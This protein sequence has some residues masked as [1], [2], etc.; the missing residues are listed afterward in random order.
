MPSADDSAEHE[1]F[2]RQMRAVNERLVVA[3]VRAEQLAEEAE[4]ARSAAADSEERFRSLVQASSAIVW[5]AD[6]S[7]TI[8]FASDAWL[9]FTGVRLDASV[10]GGWL[11]AVHADDRE[12]VQA[13]WLLAL[14]T[15][16]LYECE[17]RLQRQAGGY[18]WVAS[19]AVPIVRGGVAREWI[20]MMSD[21]TERIE[22]E[23]AREQFM[24]ILGHDLRSPLTAISISGQALQHLKLDPPYGLLVDDL[25]EASTRMGALINDVMDFA[26]GRLGGGIPLVRKRCDVGAL[27]A[28][29][30]AEHVR[31][32]PSRSI[33][34][35]ATGDVCGEWDAGRLA[36]VMTNLL[37]NALTHGEDPIVASVVG[38]AD[39]V[40][41]RVVNHGPPIPPEVL[42]KIFE[43]FARAS[44]RRASSKPGLGLGLF[45]V[46]EIARAHGGTVDVRSTADETV[47][48]VRLPRATSET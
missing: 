13:R 2:L 22:L 48:L 5:R 16:T 38:D 34:F 6:S 37:G 40:T 41:L 43:P 10:P 45:I 12:R 26:R 9:A 31:S 3:T 46:S 35:S 47:F 4:R 33:S 1:R 20:G 30:V 19:R 14:A 11:E 39:A 17:H 15:S 42:A 28:Q 24:A 32:H 21:I 29:L 44:E 18:A 36:Q 7:G 23:Q 25:V 27:F 8:A